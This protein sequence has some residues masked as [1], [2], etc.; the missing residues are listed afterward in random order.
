MYRIKIFAFDISCSSIDLID[1]MMKNTYDLIICNKKIRMAECMVD[2][3]TPIPLMAIGKKGQNM[4][5]SKAL[6]NLWGSGENKR[7][8]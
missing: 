4:G 7:L 5:F 2:A 1:S 8:N 6:L 3:D